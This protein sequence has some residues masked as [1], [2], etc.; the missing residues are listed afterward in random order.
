MR[1]TAGAL[2]LLL[3]TPSL[4]DAQ[5]SEP[6]L[7]VLAG[8][9]I[10][11]DAAGAVVGESEVRVEHAGAML[12]EQRRVGSGAPQSLWFARFE[13]GGW[14]QLFVGPQGALR[15]FDTESPAG[16][17]PVVMGATVTTQDGRATRFR[18][19]MS[20]ASDNDMRRV[21]EST[22]DGGVTW[23]VV[24]DYTYRRAS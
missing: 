12:Y 7:D 5:T 6:T 22:R 21:L 14:R 4:S 20:R 10:L 3:L 2:L 11:H 9:W 13:T 8:R 17:W 23:Q 19:M 18:M 1:L 24:F 16:R 15:T